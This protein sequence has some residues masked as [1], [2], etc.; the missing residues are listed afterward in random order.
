MTLLR[1]L[2]SDRSVTFE[3]EYERV[4]GIGLAPRPVQRPI[5][6][7]FGG[8]SSPAYRRA[9]RLADGWIPEVGVGPEFYEARAIVSEAASQA[10]RDLESIGLQGRV[11]WGSGGVPAIVDDV[12]RW[13]EAGATHVAINT[14]IAPSGAWRQDAQIGLVSVEEHLDV[15]RACAEA[16]KLPPRV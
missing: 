13:Q 11:R 2:W 8:E 15:L 7:W 12:G 5:P 16:L 3:G 9:G 6:V 10:G 1:K 14:M 4:T